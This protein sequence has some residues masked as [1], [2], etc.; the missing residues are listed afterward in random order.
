M[1]DD[2]NTIEHE[3]TPPDGPAPKLR[4]R[5]VSLIAGVEAGRGIALLFET[6]GRL[7]GDRLVLRPLEPEPPPL[8]ISVAYSAVKASSATL[9]FVD[10]AKEAAQKAPKNR[11]PPLVVP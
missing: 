2:R 7:A 4:G 8:P 10:A 6:I 1:P 11:R 9:S 5:S 3:T